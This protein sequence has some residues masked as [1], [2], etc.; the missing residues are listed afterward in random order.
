VKVHRPEGL[1]K[2]GGRLIIPNVRASFGR[3]EAA[4]LIWLLSRG[5]EQG[6]ESWEAR[7]SEEGF[8]AVL[9]DPRTFNALMAGRELSSA[10][11]HLVFYLLVRHALLED[12]VTDRALAD[13]LSA[14]IATFGRAGRAYQ[15]QDEPVEYR[16]LTDIV[17][18]GDR[19]T[20]RRAFM[21]RAHLGEFALWLSG[22]FPDHIAAREH[23][24]GAP[25]ID[26]FEQLGSNGYRLAARYDDAEEIG[27]ADLYRNCADY[28]PAL[29]IA[30]N[31]VADRHIFPATGDRI[32]RLLRQVADQFNERAL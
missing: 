31:R 2:E 3:P 23:R 32:D 25:G 8:D 13:Y 17:A 10:P 4:Y 9:D 16:Y 24:R 18:E 1:S 11:P 20:G 29:R 26:Y 5:N 6:R 12:G 21:L 22:L 27:L 14:L 28:F 15:I 19:S 30:L 7:L